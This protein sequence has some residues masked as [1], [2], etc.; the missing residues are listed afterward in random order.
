MG[1][2]KHGDGQQ[3]TSSNPI[4]LP[5]SPLKGEENTTVSFVRL[6]WDERCLD[7]QPS[8]SRKRVLSTL[9]VLFFGSA[10]SIT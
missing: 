7:V 10:S 6:P 4:P 3:T 5:A 9:P 8:S 2:N 1:Q